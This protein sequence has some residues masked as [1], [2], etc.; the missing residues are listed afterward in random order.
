MV[1]TS[2]EVGVEGER[3]GV[4]GEVWGGRSPPYKG[5]KRFSEKA[6]LRGRG[7]GRSRGGSLLGF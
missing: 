1:L 3:D 4:V 5:S 7:P 6:L 2:G